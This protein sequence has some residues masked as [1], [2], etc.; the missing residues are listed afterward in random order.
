MRGICPQ[1]T[2]V[3]RNTVNKL[4]EIPFKESEEYLLS[5][6]PGEQG[7]LVTW[8]RSIIWWL[9]L[10]RNC[11][12]FVV[13][14]PNALKNNKITTFKRS[15]EIYFGKFNKNTYQSPA[16]LWL[17]QNNL[18]SHSNQGFLSF[19]LQGVTSNTTGVRTGEISSNFLW[20]LLFLGT[21]KSS[22]PSG[23]LSQSSIWSELVWFLIWSAGESQTI[24]CSREVFVNSEE[25]WL[26]QAPSFL[27]FTWI[28]IAS[29]D[30]RLQASADFD[31]I[32]SLSNLSL[33]YTGHLASRNWGL[34][35]KK[36]EQCLRPFFFG[37]ILIFSGRKMPW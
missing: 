37:G 24:D 26:W 36:S 35:T 6:C 15:R 14:V 16:W 25:F 30:S 4:R 20:F 7:C 18:M 11:S 31:T 19:A 9:N 12:L 22:I 27:P 34:R 17:F 10:T 8:V 23:F 21:K 13:N 1:F 32:D 2:A 28:F 33:V 5:F 3:Q 29:V